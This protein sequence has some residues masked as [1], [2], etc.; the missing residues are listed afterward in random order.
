LVI[1]AAQNQVWDDS[2]FV[3]LSAGSLANVTSIQLMV[4]EQNSGGTNLGN[5]LGPTFTPGSGAL[6]SSRQS[7]SF[8]VA[9]AT[10][11]FI[12][13]GILIQFPSGVAVNFTLRI[14]WPQIELGAFVTS[15]ILTTNAAAT[16][17]IDVIVL[18][19]QPSY[20]ANYSIFFD[21]VPGAPTATAINQWCI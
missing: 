15:P 12:R 16:R 3:K 6:G 8:T 13:P 19:S 1:A 4:S 10:A 11:A 18:A 20:G 9:S 17:P 2:A 5:D 7:Y 21:G 14:G